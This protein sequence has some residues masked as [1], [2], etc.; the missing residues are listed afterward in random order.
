MSNNQMKN[1][2]NN[3]SMFGLLIYVCLSA[4]GLTLIKTGL[5]HNTSVILDK[6]G[7]AL[8]LNW[9]LIV[10]MI[11]YVLSFLTSLLVMKSMN[12]SLY[13]PLSAGLV[14]IIVCL[15][16][17]FALKEEISFNQ[18]VGMAII[19]AGIIVM[20]VGKKG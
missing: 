16:S 7:F 8:Q 12:L 14:Y 6:S 1:G 9:I 11:L 10:G 19:F 5:N 2:G 20:N 3:L 15:I 17:K 4:T 13:Y 18:V